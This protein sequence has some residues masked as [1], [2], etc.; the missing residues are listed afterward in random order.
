MNDVAEYL[1]AA[2]E[3]AKAQKKVHEFYRLVSQVHFSLDA[4]R[5][6]DFAKR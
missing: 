6:F 4:S 1:T 3:F 5:R 2:Q